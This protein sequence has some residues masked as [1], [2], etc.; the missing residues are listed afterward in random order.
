[1]LLCLRSSGVSCE[2]SIGRQ[3]TALF[4]CYFNN[5][6]GKILTSK[7]KLKETSLKGQSSRRL[8]NKT[9]TNIECIKC[10]HKNHQTL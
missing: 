10:R 7:D 6:Y 1:M 2:S 3:L 5:Y 9:K 4:H 8:K